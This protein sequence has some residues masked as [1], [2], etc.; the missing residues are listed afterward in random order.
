MNGVNYVIRLTNGYVLSIPTNAPIDY[1]ETGNLV[2]GGEVYGSYFI[3]VGTRPS[4]LVDSQKQSYAQQPWFT[5][6]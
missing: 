3:D 4:L 1:V 6:S 5:R 2:S